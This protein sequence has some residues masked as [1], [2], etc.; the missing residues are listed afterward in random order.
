MI[1]V[2][3]SKRRRKENISSY[4]QQFHQIPKS[5]KKNNITVKSTVIGEYNR[6]QK[7]IG[8]IYREQTMN[9]DNLNLEFID[10][11]M[12]N[13]K[14]IYLYNI[15]ENSLIQIPFNG[16]HI[17]CCWYKISSDHGTYQSSV[18]YLYELSLSADT[19]EIIEAF[20]RE[21]CENKTSLQIQ[22]FD[23]KI[24]LF[25]QCGNVQNRTDDTLIIKEEDK[26]K[27]LSDIDKFVL[28]E[29]EAKYDKF[30]IPYKLNY[31]LYV[32]IHA[33]RPI[34]NGKISIKNTTTTTTNWNL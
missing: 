33:F 18:T 1:S 12:N 17:D 2:A 30:G 10:F 7:L 11:S 31:Y 14:P 22:Y 27:L 24:G 19:N 5:S 6:I 20:I 26:K 29:T 9:T 15:P 4:D 28:P 21:A 25:M 16:S 8:K 34:L 3:G 32:Y 13:E 23:A